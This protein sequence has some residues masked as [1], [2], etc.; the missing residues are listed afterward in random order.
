MNKI[1]IVTHCW[2]KNLDQYAWHLQLQL[3]SVF[4]FAP[5]ESVS[6]TVCYAGDDTLTCE[7]L[8]FFEGKFNQSRGGRLQTICLPHEQLFRRA[9][10]R[11]L[12]ALATKADLVWFADVDY[13][14]K[15]GAFEF[16]GALQADQQRDMMMPLHVL[17]HVSWEKGDELVASLRSGGV[18]LAKVPNDE[19]FGRR[20]EKIPIGGMQIARGDFCRK[21]GYLNGTKWIAPLEPAPESFPSFRDDIAFRRAVNALQPGTAGD[22]RVDIPAVY[23]VRHSENGYG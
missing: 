17:R 3:S 14:W 2:A 4:W 5:M 10:G 9:I 19:D 22:I 6:V 20:R 18:G 11:N 16:L 15:E 7:V 13:F 23:R 12:A 8:R 21:H 1:E